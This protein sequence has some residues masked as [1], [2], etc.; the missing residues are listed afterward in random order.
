MYEAGI[1]DYSVPFSR[2]TTRWWFHRQRD[3]QTVAGF[4]IFSTDATFFTRFS[5]LLRRVFW[6]TVHER[7]AHFAAKT[8]WKNSVNS[9][10]ISVN[11]TRPSLHKMIYNQLGAQ[12]HINA[13]NRPSGNSSVDN[14]HAN[15]IRSP[16]I[17]WD[18]GQDFNSIRRESSLVVSPSSKVAERYS[19]RPLYFNISISWIAHREK[20]VSIIW[21]SWSRQSELATRRERKD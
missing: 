1:Q 19:E 13:R 16:S 21:I 11:L 18:S 8:W 15:W 4:F 10:R 6:T 2:L 9:F 12:L 5:T 3:F 17:V 7:W 14:W 20:L